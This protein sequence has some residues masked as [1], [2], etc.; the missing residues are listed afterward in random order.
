MTLRDE[1]LC[2]GSPK[3]G[4]EMDANDL[5]EVAERLFDVATIFSG[6]RELTEDRWEA[7]KKILER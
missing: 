3:T 5:A 6:D 1:I 2:P 4:R 7:I